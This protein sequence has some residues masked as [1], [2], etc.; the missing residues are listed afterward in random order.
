MCK[1]IH[2]GA[3]G[4]NKQYKCWVNLIIILCLLWDVLNEL[5]NYIKKFSEHWYVYQQGQIEFLRKLSS[6]HHFS[7]NLWDIL[8]WNQ[9]LHRHK[10]SNWWLLQQYYLNMRCV[11][12]WFSK[13]LTSLE[14]RCLQRIRLFCEF[15]KCNFAR[16]YFMLDVFT[17]SKNTLGDDISYTLFYCR[18]NK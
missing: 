11:V 3:E 15:V 18:R 14:N 17:Y 2:F 10:G 7:L 4:I 13:I 8:I 5:E 12:L 6:H 1:C 16:L 9:R